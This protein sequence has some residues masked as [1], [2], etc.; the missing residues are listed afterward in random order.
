MPTPTSCCIKKPTLRDCR[1]CCCPKVNSSSSC[2]NRQFLEL[3]APIRGWEDAPKEDPAGGIPHLPLWHLE[4][5]IPHSGKAEPT[6]SSAPLS[7]GQQLLPGS[8]S[9]PFPGL[10]APPSLCQE[11]LASF[12]IPSLEA[13]LKWEMMCQAWGAAPQ[14]WHRVR[15]RGI[16]LLQGWAEGPSW[17]GH[18]PWIPHS[19]KGSVFCSPTGME[20][21]LIAPSNIQHCSRDKGQ[22]RGWAELLENRAPRPGAVWKPL[23]FPP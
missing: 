11:G 8:Q 22:P 14:R 13:G 18:T 20:P 21:A 19:H 15:G 1:S 10:L 4:T 6:L 7:M 9:R 16:L 2:G 12:G 17:A 5:A 23:C 3:L